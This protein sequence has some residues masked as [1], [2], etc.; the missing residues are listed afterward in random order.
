[1]SDD[2][3]TDR[4]SASW[5]DPD[6]EPEMGWSTLPGGGLMPTRD[7]MRAL[8]ERDRDYVGWRAFLFN[9]AKRRKDDDDDD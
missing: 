1:M 6:P 2:Y 8:R 7:F 3:G 5:A 4:D 9:S